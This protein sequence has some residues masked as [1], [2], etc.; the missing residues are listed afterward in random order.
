MGP[1]LAGPLFSG[2]GFHPRRRRRAGTLFLQVV[3]LECS[4]LGR[5]NQSPF[6]TLL[7]SRQ[8]DLIPKPLPALL[9]VVHGHNRPAARRRP[10]G[11]EDLAD[12][13]AALARMNCCKRF[14]VLVLRRARKLM[15]DRVGHGWSPSD[16][17][18]PL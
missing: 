5:P 8:E 4:F 7:H 13:E 16:R 6:D 17:N 18:T 10:S 11:M 9:G 14:L 1:A 2:S 15:H 12:W 3:N